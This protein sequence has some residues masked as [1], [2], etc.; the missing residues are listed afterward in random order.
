M[1]CYLYARVSSREQEREGFSIPAQRKML[2]EYA[3]MKG[4]TIVR[5]FVDVETAKSPGRKEFREMVRLLEA[6]SSCRIVLVE[7]TDRLYRNP[8]DTWRFG[9][10]IESNDVIVHLVKEGLVLD[11]NARSTDKFRHDIQVAL[12]KH[13]IDNLKEEVKKGMHE[14]AE[15]G[16]YPGRAAFG[17]RHDR[18]NRTIVTDPEKSTIVKRMFD[19][20]D[21]GHSSVDAVRQLVRNE[22]G[23]TMP[24][25]QAHNILRNV[26]YTGLFVWDK[27]TYTG[28]HPAIVGPDCFKRVQAILAGR[29]HPKR[30]GHNFAFGGGLLRCA[31]DGCTVTA[32]LHTKPNQKQYVYYRCSF[33]QGKMRP[34]IHA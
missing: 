7:K 5:E 34:A 24:R 20:Y 12:A 18:V 8:T 30:H 21:D 28:Q 11:K 14:K 25:S 4:L 16:M 9:Q 3:A 17:Y 13:Y 2:R 27:K 15:Q 1:K 32:E 22:F 29:S 26:F 10:L 23:I 33:W 31:F 6:D 19:A